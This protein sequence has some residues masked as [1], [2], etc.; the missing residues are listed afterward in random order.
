M[1]LIPSTHS[2]FAWFQAGLFGGAGRGGPGRLVAIGG[3]L[4]CMAGGA[5]LLSVRHGNGPPVSQVAKMKPG[6]LLP[7]GLQGTPAQDALQK[8]DSQEK[9]RAAEE[10]HKSYTPPIPSSTP[11][12][13]P[14]PAEVGMG[15]PVAPD[16]PAAK[17]VPPPPAIVT[18]APPA[19]T[20]PERPVL[21]PAAGE[22]EIN[23]ARVT[24][25]AAGDGEGDETPE[26][27]KSAREQRRKAIGDLVNS[28][29][30]RPPQ[31]TVVIEPTSVKQGADDP[32]ALGNRV[33]G[34]RADSGV[35]GEKVLV[36]AGRGIYAHTVLAVNSDTNG[37]IVLEADTGPISGDRMIGTF[38]KSGLDRL[39]VKVETVEHRGKQLEA[40]GVVVAPDSME[41]AVASSVDEHYVE[42]FVLPAAAAF[43]S[44]LGQAVALGNSTSTV[45]PFGGTTQTFGPLSFKQEAMVAGGAAATAVS[46]AMTAS[47]PKGPTVHLAA[48]VSVGVM[49]LSN[50]SVK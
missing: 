41:T 43:M 19:F 3:V 21:D 13:G 10:A 5:F 16:V 42:R 7:G 45:S 34:K 15:A 36:P 27:A 35:T 25:V 1:S 28:W 48:N 30:T 47:T 8:K 14:L 22:D 12:N 49:F 31:T 29:S 40:N 32:P 17:P 6:N 24:K 9:A 33:G 2:R 11:F 44:G 50:L 20:P 37:P 46:N 18:P 38:S 23:G 26:E 4:A 39:I